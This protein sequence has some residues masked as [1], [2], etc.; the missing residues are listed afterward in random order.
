MKNRFIRMLS[1]LCTIMLMTGLVSVWASAEET[2][3]TPTDLTPSR[4]EEAAV[5]EEEETVETEDPD[6]YFSEEPFEE[7]EDEAWSDDTT[8]GW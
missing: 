6:A 5:P 7:S 3:A 4:E 1:I 2:A 8:A